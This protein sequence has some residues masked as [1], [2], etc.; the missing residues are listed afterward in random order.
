M[1]IILK[2]TRAIQDTP[3]KKT[4]T[5]T[6]KQEGPNGPGLLTWEI[7]QISQWSPFTEDHSMMLQTKHQDYRLSKTHVCN[8]I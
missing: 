1:H 4:T 8:S 5:E 6:R 3:H 7:G 2:K